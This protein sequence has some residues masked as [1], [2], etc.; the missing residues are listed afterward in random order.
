[1]W[2]QAGVGFYPRALAVSGNRL[3][4][5]GS[6]DNWLSSPLSIGD[7]VIPVPA[8]DLGIIAQLTDNGS[9]GSFGWA[10]L[11]G[12]HSYDYL[13]NIMGLAVS[14]AQVYALGSFVSNT[15]TFGPYTLNSTNDTNASSW[16][17]KE[18]LYITRLTD[19]GAA[20]NV[21]WARLMPA[22]SPAANHGWP[23]GLAVDNGGVYVTGRNITAFVVKFSTDGNYQWGNRFG[24]SLTIP[25]SLAVQAGHVYVAGEFFD[26]TATFGSTTLTQA[27]GA[28]QFS[29][30]IFVTRLSDAGTSATTDWAVR[31]GG[32]QRDSATAL[33]ATANGV[34]L[35]GEFEGTA[36]FG[37]TTLSSQGHSDVFVARLTEIAGSPAFDWALPAGSTNADNG[38]GLARSGNSLYVVGSIGGPATF[39]PLAISAL[40]NSG[41]GFLARITDP[42][43]PTTAATTLPGLALYPNPAHTTATMRLPASLTSLATLTLLDA[44]GRTVRTATVPPGPDY[45]LDLTGLAPGVYALRVQADGATATR[46]LAVE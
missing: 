46:R 19:E 22:G 5:A 36:T 38:S 15:A 31:A 20:A 37:G 2:A 21:D 43:L 40:N 13:S 12:G 45:A 14:G 33:L 9:T 24:S 27:A 10:K 42:L 11:V 30:D 44:L 41:A 39:A 7:H 8:D 34:Y 4:I 3:Y 1:M 23:Y 26:A 28:E 35:T 18:D 16:Q 29:T 17:R 25:A 32:T 6:V